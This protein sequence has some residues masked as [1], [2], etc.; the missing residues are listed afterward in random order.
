MD[1]SVGNL[2]KSVVGAVA[3]VA[4]AVVNAL[5][6]VAQ[7]GGILGSLAGAVV[8][9]AAAL[10]NVCEDGEIS[11]DEEELLEDAFKLLVGAFMG[12]FG[13]DSSHCDFGGEYKG[14][15][16]NMMKQCYGFNEEEAELIRKAYKSSEIN[17]KKSMS[18]EEELNKLY[19]NMSAL[20]FNYDGEATSTGAKILLGGS[21]WKATGNIPST[22]EAMK[23]F[24]SVGMSE[25][26]IRDLVIAINR[27]HGNTSEDTFE[28]YGIDITKSSLNNYGYNEHQKN[29]LEGEGK[30]FAHEI[31]QLAIFSNSGNVNRK[32]LRIK[33]IIDVANAGKTNEMSSYKGDIYSTRMDKGDVLSDLDGNNIYNRMINSTDNLM[34]V[35]N[36]Y[37]ESVL[38]GET[39]RAEEFYKHY[40][41]GDI[42]KGK[43]EVR[44]II[45]GWSIGS[46]YITGDLIGNIKDGLALNAYSQSD[47]GFKHTQDYVDEIFDEKELKKNEVDDKKK[48]FFDIVKQ[49]LDKG[50]K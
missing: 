13:S 48:E 22:K 12:M 24:Q 25:D 2:V 32:G 49:E 8:G 31:V 7:S 34:N 6:P 40:G 38:N 28:K 35:Y 10:A 9:V 20:C 14:N 33:D 46:D 47:P 50:V 21:R 27:Q 19:G 45:D 41:D 44:N 43:E 1:F 37:N 23:Y 39:N 36:N 17:K 4:T 18:R 29:M 5:S 26:E 30:D 3:K 11:E 42:E 15:Y 16:Y